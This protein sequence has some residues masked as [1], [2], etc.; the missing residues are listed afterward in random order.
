MTN[1]ASKAASEKKDSSEI[2]QDSVIDN[3]ECALTFF[4]V[5]GSETF[6]LESLQ[7]K[8]CAIPNLVINII[9]TPRR[10]SASTIV[11]NIKM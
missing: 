6:F 2:N 5:G 8:R 7:V 10:I 3:I 1:F 9:Q 11:K 4:D